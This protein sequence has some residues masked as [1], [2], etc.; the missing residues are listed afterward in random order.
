ME[1]IIETIIRTAFDESPYTG[2]SCILVFWIGFSW[3]FKLSRVGQD[4]TIGEVIL[5]SASPNNLS[6]NAENLYKLANFKASL[7]SDSQC[8][9]G[10][11]YLI[12]WVFEG[13]SYLV[14]GFTYLIAFSIFSIFIFYMAQ[15]ENDISLLSVV[16]GLGRVSLLGLIILSILSFIKLWTSVNNLPI[17]LFKKYKPYQL[18]LL[19]W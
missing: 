15:P 8:K 4:K 16:D 9:I 10:T 11:L 1:S 17:P 19:G 12:Y 2:F 13:T 18:I 14:K 6:I 7:G 5:K 3:W